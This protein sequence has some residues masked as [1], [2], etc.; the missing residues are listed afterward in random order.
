MS[1]FLSF[2]KTYFE[3]AAHLAWRHSKDFADSKIKVSDVTEVQVAPSLGM[4]GA[5]SSTFV[6][7]FEVLKSSID[8]CDFRATTAKGTLVASYRWN[9]ATSVDNYL[10]LFRSAGQGK[11]L[12]TQHQFRMFFDWLYLDQTS[13]HYEK[14]TGVSVNIGSAPTIIDGQHR[15]IYLD[16]SLQFWNEIHTDL[17]QRIDSF[18]TAL[19][20]LK[21]V[22]EKIWTKT[23]LRTAFR[24]VV[25]RNASSDFAPST[26][27]WIHSFAL[28]TGISPP[29]KASVADVISI[30]RAQKPISLEKQR[31]VF[32]R[33]ENRAG[34]ARSPRSGSSGR[35]S[36]ARCSQNRHSAG[37]HSFGRGTFRRSW[38]NCKDARY[39]TA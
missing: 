36:N 3:A 30:L 32:C 15:I 28:L 35:N 11:A 18:T 23:R 12:A 22:R 29:K 37:N 33:Q 8:E 31:D 25:S 14:I 10:E 1:F 16:D 27:D 13:Q 4:T 9:E 39:Q 26:C 24:C 20:V 5:V 21:Y 19:D 7:D 34:G 17:V 6:N 38:A 2:S